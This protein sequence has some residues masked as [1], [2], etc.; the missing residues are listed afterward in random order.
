MKKIVV[1]EPI[2]EDGKS[3]LLERDDVSA[4]FVNGDKSAVLSEIV[5]AHAILVRT[6]ILTA[7][8]LQRAP[9][10][11]VVSRHGVGCDNIDVRH[12]SS[13]SIPVAIATDSN[14]ISVV[15]HVLM[16]MLS[17]NKRARLYDQLTRQGSFDQRGMHHTSE[18]F[19]KHILIVG[20]G[21]IGKRLAPVCKAFGMR[22]TVADIALDEEYAL[23][24]GVDTTDDFTSVLSE[25]DYLTLHVPLDES[26]SG[27]ISASELSTLPSHAVVINCARGGIVDEQ[28]LAQAVKSGDIAAAG[29]D[30]F[31]VEPPPNGHPLFDTGAT[32]L[33]PHNAASTAEGLSRMASFAAQNILD[34]FD[35]S[36]TS[37]RAIN[38]L[39][40]KQK[41]R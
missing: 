31:A 21:R 26:T 2:H 22:V 1:T 17:L 12:C 19:G 20:F 5:D 41:K 18:L 39:V 40:L 7:E 23:A 38:P 24:I 13:R 30:V 33:S 3:V 15:E 25:T 34:A 8:D 4:V 37:D 6:M 32:I 27:M 35:G 36:L 10:L 9:G 16:M 14:T 11:E 28:A 29:V